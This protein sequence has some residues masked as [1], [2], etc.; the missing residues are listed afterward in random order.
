M[1]ASMNSKDNISMNK[2]N[3]FEAIMKG[4]VVLFGIGNILRG[5]DG[6]GPILLERLKG[7]VNAVCINAENA[8]EK[9]L[10]KII[11]ENPDT[12]LIIDAVHLNLGPGE[13]EIIS[14]SNLRNTGFTTHDISL[15]MLI[16][17]LKTEINSK[18]YILGVQPH[19]LRLGDEISESIDNTI[20]IIA[21]MIIEALPKERQ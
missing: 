20:S 6:L 13:Y 17:Y 9:Y 21:N 1:Y 5:D 11:K 15:T 8:P 3:P 18:I 7:R 4:K 19:R 10:G 14:S 12:L 2:S 16:E